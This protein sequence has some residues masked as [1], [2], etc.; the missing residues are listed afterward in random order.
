MELELHGELFLKIFK[1][2]I[3][4]FQK[5]KAKILDVY[6]VELYLHIKSQFKI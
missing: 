3:C 2:D 6:D 5:L 1:I 4:K